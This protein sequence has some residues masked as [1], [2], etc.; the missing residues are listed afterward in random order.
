MMVENLKIGPKCNELPPLQL[1]QQ[2][3]SNK[4]YKLKIYKI[5]VQYIITQMSSNEIN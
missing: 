2:N 3:V 4:K 1:I 5:D